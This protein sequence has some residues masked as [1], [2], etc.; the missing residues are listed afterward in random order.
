M[1]TLPLRLGTRGV[2]GALGWAR[3]LVLVQ[4]S[5]S[6]YLSP[7]CLFPF[8]KGEEVMDKKI[9]EATVVLDRSAG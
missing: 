2:E 1:W 5:P 6:G 7:L 9:P 8:I 4:S 3:A